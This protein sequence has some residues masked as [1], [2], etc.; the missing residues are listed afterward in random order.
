MTKNDDLETK[1]LARPSTFDYFALSEALKEGKLLLLGPGNKKIAIAGPLE[2]VL[3]EAM[4]EL[5]R[6]RQV[7][8][9]TSDLL[10]TSQDAAD[11]LSISRPT[12]VQLLTDGKIPYTQAGDGKHR[13]IRISDLVEYQNQVRDER[14]EHL[15][16]MVKIGQEMMADPDFVEPSPEELT[17]IIKEIRRENAE[18]RRAKGNS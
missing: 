17:R 8:V 4:T 6:G 5:S 13:R 18:R 9:V 7:Q 2:K 15:A 14:R 12:L 1:G 11:Y 3:Q 10:I 16:S